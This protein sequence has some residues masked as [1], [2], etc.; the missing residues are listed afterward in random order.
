M[1]KKNK[2]YGFKFI[3]SVIIDRKKKIKESS[4]D[5]IKIE[6]GVNLLAKSLHPEVQNLV[7]KNIRKHGNDCSSF[8]LGPDPENGT[9]ELAYFS[10]G[11]YL[12]ISLEIGDLKISRPYSLSSSPKESL[13]GI[14]TITVKRVDGGLASNYILDNWIIGTKVKASAPAGNFD[15]VSLRDSKH[16][17]GI[18][19]GSGITPFLSYAKSLQNGD[20]D[21]ELTLLYGSRDPSSI[22]FK[23]ELD[24]IA[25]TTPNFKVIYVLSESSDDGYEHGYLTSD[26][27]KKYS[28][29]HIVSV[30]LCGPQAMYDF[31]DNE[32]LKLKLEKK[33]IRHELFGEMHDPSSQNDY[34][35][36]ENNVFTI[37]V[38]I[39]SETTEIKANANQTI[40]QSL[41][42]SGIVAPNK[43]RSGECGYCRAYLKSGRV[44]APKS[45]EH[46]RYA[47]KTNN[48]IHTC[49]TYPL[50][51]LEIYM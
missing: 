25:A 10:S 24:E 44:Y 28:G 27:I 36:T 2:Y 19:G 17:I 7:V 31:V 48:W 15:Y 49:C 16:V 43:C 11:Q 26:L 41:E 47:D 51:N 37:K 38:S 6:F 13:D 22:L 32:L 18:A 39:N 46:R 23:K 30:F 3:K 12:S 4:N 5:N 1:S 45:L 40:L 8:D 9:T 29:N 20:E 21:F 14:Y 35:K 34:I 33:F 50:S 42:S